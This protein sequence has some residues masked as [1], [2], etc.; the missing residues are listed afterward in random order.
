MPLVL[1]YARNANFALPDLLKL[2]GKGHLNAFYNGRLYLHKE[3]VCF[4]KPRVAAELKRGVQYRPDE[5]DLEM[6]M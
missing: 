3:L 6:E 1:R 4:G 5:L 2:I